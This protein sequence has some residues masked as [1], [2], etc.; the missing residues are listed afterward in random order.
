MPKNWK[1]KSQKRTQKGRKRTWLNGKWTTT[2]L[3]YETTKSCIKT[4]SFATF[5]AGDDA[6]ED[7]ECNALVAIYLF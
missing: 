4:E 5:H 3:S 2:T 6:N 7:D 1:R